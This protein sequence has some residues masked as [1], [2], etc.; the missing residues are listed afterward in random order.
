MSDSPCQAQ[1]CSLQ[2]CLNKN[3]YSP[4]KCNAQLRRLYECCDD[5]YK[6]SGEGTEST[7]CPIPRVVTRWLKNHPA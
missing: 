1:A 4:D 3:T 6:K 7:A 5:M 2:T